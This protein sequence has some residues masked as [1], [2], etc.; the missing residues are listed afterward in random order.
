MNPIIE[1][2]NLTKCFADH[3]A[4]NNISLKI[5]QGDIYGLIGRNGA[6]KTTFM[7]MISNLSKPSSGTYQIFPS[8]EKDMKIK[9]TR[10]SALIENVGSYPTMTAYDNMLLKGKSLGL[11]RDSYI[12]ETLNLLGLG[13]VGKKKIK[14]FSLGMKQRLGIALAL[15][16]NPDIMILDEPINGLDP[17]GI[18]D[19]RNIIAELNRERN[20]TFL[21]SSHILDELAKL[22]TNFAIIDNGYL[23]ANF[24]K[25]DLEESTKDRIEVL[26]DDP[27]KAILV[28]DQGQIGSYRLVDDNMIHIYVDSKY[29]NDIISCLY[30][31]G[32]K[33]NY[34]NVHNTSLEEYYIKLLENKGV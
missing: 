9:Q 20:I 33:I 11:S 15:V 24:S 2:K 31:A 14:D 7:K 21:I 25:K 10:V 16:G 12:Y 18:I 29:T 5:N 19:I 8:S 13:K 26:T 27:K 30:E 6:G 32:I 22:A 1:T 34:F 17:Q 3:K 4:V 23:V 28:L